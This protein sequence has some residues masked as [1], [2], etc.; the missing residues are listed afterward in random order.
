MCFAATLLRD[1]P[2]RAYSIVE[3]VE[4][5]LVLAEKGVR[6]A[7]ADEAHVDGEMVSTAAAARSQRRR[8]EEGRRAL[9]RS[10]GPS[11]VWSALVRRDPLLFD[12]AADLLVPPLSAL[13]L[14]ASA[15]TLLSHALA[16]RLAQALWGASLFALAAYGARGW[17]LSGT[18]W[19]GLASLVCA[20]AYVVWKIT[21]TLHRSPSADAWIRTSREGKPS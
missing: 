16:A 6:V 3:D 8:W 5:G 9:A 20:P 21:V 12:I 10:R 4:Y 19:Q 18:G 1:V 14:C 11:L 15:G 2:P 13:A 7:Y 17:A